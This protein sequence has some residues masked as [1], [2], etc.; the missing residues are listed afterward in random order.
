MTDRTA[1]DLVDLD[2]LPTIEDVANASYRE[3]DTYYRCTGCGLQAQVPA[4]AAADV[5]PKH[6]TDSKCTGK[7]KEVNR[8]D[9]L[10]HDE[11]TKAMLDSAIR[12]WHETRGLDQP[13]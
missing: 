13:E 11:T 1:A 3:D 10:E 6:A 4:S 8:R 5:K 12:S 9:F 7:Y 2:P